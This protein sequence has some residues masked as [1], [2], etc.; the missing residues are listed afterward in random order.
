[1]YLIG[2]K[3]IIFDSL[4]SPYAALR[5]DRKFGRTGAVLGRLWYFIERSLLRHSDSIIT[6]TRL[7]T[8]FLSECFQLP[9]A[10]IHAVPVGA[11]ETISVT[12]P[13]ADQSFNVLF[14]GSFL[15]LHGMDIILRAAGL[16]RDEP[17][18]FTFIG[19]SGRRL[20]EFRKSCRSLQLSRFDHLDWVDFGELLNHHVGSAHLC[21]GGP[22]GNTPQARRVMTGKAMQ[23]M[24]LGK[25]TVIGEVDEDFGLV[26][27]HNCLLAKQGDPEALAEAIAWGYAN[28]EKLSQIGENGRKLY[29][30]RLS[31]KCIVSKMEEVLARYQSPTVSDS[32]R[33]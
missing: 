11:V 16:L 26:D 29:Q 18:H 6:D 33:C 13:V 1:L 15:P 20:A 25:A 23:C 22:F 21:L 9:S 14:Y 10:K 30:E 32:G 3:P 7:H 5:E 12:S 24:A 17:I 8:R 28:R 27:K 4:M 19:G 31:I 2:G